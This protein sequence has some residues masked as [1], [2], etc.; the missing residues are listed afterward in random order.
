MGAPRRGCPTDWGV[1]RS[2]GG[3]TFKQDTDARARVHLFIPELRV[4]LNWGSE[5]KPLTKV[6]CMYPEGDSLCVMF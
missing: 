5:M 3:V 4:P 2:P 1:A 6:V